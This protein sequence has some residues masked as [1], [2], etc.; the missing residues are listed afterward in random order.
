MVCKH[1]Q[2]PLIS[3]S[4]I[5]NNNFRPMKLLVLFLYLGIATAGWIAPEQ[6][7][8][9]WTEN[10]NEMRVTW[11]N[12]L[13]VSAGAIY[14]P[15]LCGGVPTP[16]NFTSSVVNT[17][18]FL[19]GNVTFNHYQYIHTSVFK[20]IKSECWYQYQVSNL[21]FKS[22]VYMFNGRTPDTDTTFNDV[23][24]PLT[25]V[26]FGDWGTGEFAQYTKYLLE[27]EAKARDFAGILHMGDLA[28][29][30]DDDNGKV[31]DTYLRMIEPIAAEFPYMVAPGNHESFGNWSHYKARFNMPINEANQ[32][33]GYFYSLN[34][35]PVHFIMY[36]SNS[37]QSTKKVLQAQNEKNWI[38]QDLEE[39]NKHR[40]IRPWIVVLAH[41]P[42]YCSVDWTGPRDSWVDCYEQAVVMIAALEEVFYE[43]GVD[44]VL[45]AHVHNY[46]R[47]AAIYHNETVES[48]YDDNHTHINPRAPVF[49]MSGIAGN[50][51]QHNVPASNTPQ[52]W[53]RYL[54]N[55][56]GYG[57]L[58]AY[59]TTHLYWEQFSA[60]QLTEI[61]YVW[62][63]K[64]RPR[65]KPHWW[66]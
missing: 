14:R 2:S 45:Q 5:L 40:A 63:I 58:T 8:L 25:M 27:Q 42:L 4:I 31:G 64:D 21:G 29:N 13:P 47:D 56:Y 34:L 57:R 39:A 44:L 46:E 49:I 15:I 35:G 55:D 9:S 26:I 36:N 3:E 61:D 30:L 43:A 66:Q 20:N 48:E 16:S 52:P 60:Q 32:G 23:Q 12:Y 10:S 65:Y 38:I 24:N 50:V 51:L 37:F 28:Y 62:I 1:L 7:H 18:V 19:Q 59:N 17:T 6:I 22:E 54:S 41:H 33:T 11:V 53:A